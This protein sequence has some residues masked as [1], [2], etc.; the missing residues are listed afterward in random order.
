MLTH[1]V[2]RNFAIIKHLE[3]PFQQGFTVLTGETGAGKSI[4]IDALNLLLGGRA[5][6]EVI[7]T[8]EDEAVV[9]G[10]FEPRGGAAARI[11]AR[12]EER[13]ID[14]DG[15]LIIRRIV[16]RSGRNKVFLNGSLTTLSTLSELTRELVDISGQHEH[17]SLVRVEGHIELLDNYAGHDEELQE[18]AEVYKKVRALERE[19][20]SMREDDRERLHRVD[21]LRYQLAEIDAAKLERGEEERHATEVERLRYAEKISEAVHFAARN[22]YDDQG[23]AIER[24]GEAITALRRVES[25]DTRLGGLAERLEEAQILVEDIARELQ[26]YSVDGGDDTTRLDNL[27][28]RLEMIKKLCRKH[29][30]SIDEIL[31]NAGAMRKELHRL[32]NAEEH[33][34]SL[35]KE[36][37]EARQKAWKV[38]R[39]LSKKRRAAALELCQKIEGELGELNMARAQF[40]ASFDPPELP[41]TS[42]PAV[43]D[44]EG[45]VLHSQG[46][47][48]L[49]FL[50]APNPGEEPKPLAKIA[51]GGELSRIML[52]IKTV[53]VEGDTIG[54]YVFDEVDTGIGGA[55]A[56]IVGAKI[57]KTSVSHQVL[58]ITHL[59]SIA[60]RADHHYLVEKELV[61]GRTQST[62][63]PLPPEERIEA[64][65]CML[66]GARVTTKTREAARDLLQEQVRERA[67]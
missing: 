30:A 54:T 62:I 44:K 36:L 8:E 12:L 27:I 47:D 1:L 52:A 65:A 5:S 56:D 2:I 18:M 45:P 57:Q 66:G 60:S 19:L 3:I 35:K 4:V 16:S 10:V 61:E 53:L 48:T 26:E 58:C 20:K 14:F 38:A 55:T 15:Q 31:D 28:A 64:I 22:T 41:G 33:T 6:A 21:F 11:V 13:G 40:R 34:E 59:A 37:Q 63:R 9:E 17:Y 23:A 50:L 67:S 39:E 32:E 49:E 24:L 43:D 25:F 29:G 51:S 46:F 42:A 7:R